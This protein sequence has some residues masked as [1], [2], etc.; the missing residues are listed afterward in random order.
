MDST[1]PRTNLILEIFQKFISK[2][3]KS[4]S[5]KDTYPIDC[6]D[7]AGVEI[8]GYSFHYLQGR[9]L[10][11][12]TGWVERIARHGRPV[13]KFSHASVGSAERNQNSISIAGFCLTNNFPHFHFLPLLLFLQP[14]ADMIWVG[15]A[16]AEQDTV[17]GPQWKDTLHAKL[18]KSYLP[19]CRVLALCTSLALIIPGSNSARSR[20]F[21]LD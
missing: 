19:R 1:F 21:L 14:A 7:G 3:E 9:K 15:L 5:L 16:W 4:S 18:I 6:P 8:I 11:F 13:G 17:S 12:P 20:N 2:R 10:S